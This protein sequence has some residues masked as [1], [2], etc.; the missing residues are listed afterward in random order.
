MPLLQK[1]SWLELSVSSVGSEDQNGNILKH[2]YRSSS[3]WVVY[4]LQQQW[5]L[6]NQK[7]LHNK[8]AK[9]R[10]A[11]QPKAPGCPVCGSFT[12]SPYKNV[13]KFSAFHL[14][15]NLCIFLPFHYCDHSWE[16]PFKVFAGYDCSLIE[17]FTASLALQIQPE[18]DNSSLFCAFPW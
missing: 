17:A 11:G 8:V 18:L 4:I 3:L 14:E 6:L 7:D 15:E 12:S 1:R 9:Q 16:S 5:A 13:N 10:V 2:R